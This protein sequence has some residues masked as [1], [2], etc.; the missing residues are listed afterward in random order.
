MSRQITIRVS[1]QQLEAYGLAAQHAG[2]AINLW[3]RDIVKAAVGKLP[4]LRA[5][6]AC[7]VKGKE[8]RDQKLCLWLPNQLESLVDRA[9]AESGVSATTWCTLILDVAA[10][11]SRLAYYLKRVS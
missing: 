6:P 4:K 1:P 11:I 9:A 2:I 3:A 10:G 5:A 7:A 8:V